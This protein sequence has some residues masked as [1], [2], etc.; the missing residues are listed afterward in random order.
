MNRSDEY[1]RKSQHL[2]AGLKAYILSSLTFTFVLARRY[3]CNLYEGVLGQA[4]LHTGSL[5]PV[6]WAD[7]FIPHFVHLG[8]ASNVCQVNRC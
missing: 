5:W 4:Y 7:P 6:F 1:P 2:L 8:L 3:D